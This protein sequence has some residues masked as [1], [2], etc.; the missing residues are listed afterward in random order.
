MANTFVIVPLAKQQGM[1]AH[2][3]HKKAHQHKESVFQQLVD[4]L[5]DTGESGK[6]EEVVSTSTSMKKQPHTS[7]KHQ[8]HAENSVTCGTSESSAA[9]VDSQT[10]A[11]EGTVASETAKSADASNGSVDTNGVQSV[12]NALPAHVNVGRR[13]LLR[14]HISAEL[15]A[16][17]QEAP[18][19]AV[20]SQGTDRTVSV[21]PFFPEAP[22][23]VLTAPSSSAAGT[24]EE[25]A[26]QMA[27]S[28]AASGQQAGPSAFVLP[29]AARMPGEPVRP[30]AAS[31]REI[32]AAQTVDQAI[33]NGQSRQGLA[34]GGQQADRR[35]IPIPSVSEASV[36]VLTVPSSSAAGTGEDT[37]AGQ[38]AASLAA[39]G[40]QAGPSASV[41]PGAARVPGEP[42]RPSA[43]SVREMHAAQTVD[44]AALVGQAMPSFG[45][46]TGQA[47]RLAFMQTTGIAATF[48]SD[49]DAASSDEQVGDTSRLSVFRRDVPVDRHIAFGDRF[50][51]AARQVLTDSRGTE[52]QVVHE[53]NQTT[54]SSNVLPTN[55]AA[56]VAS[57]QMGAI[58]LWQSYQTTGSQAPSPPTRQVADQLGSWF[59][60]STFQGNEQGGTM[61]TLTL[62]P[63]SLG[64]VTVT[65][66]QTQDGITARL[67]TETRTAHDL[68]KAG[69][70]ELKNDLAAQGVAVQ[71]I[72]VGRQ[73]ERA[74]ES[75]GQQQH[76]TDQHSQQQSDAR[77]DEERRDNESRSQ[78]FEA[79][80]VSNSQFDRVL[81]EGSGYM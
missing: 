3:A 66:V 70:G 17:E 50:T 42:V 31:V 45:T 44:Q 35:A 61:L 13:E 32:H 57:R 15:H 62:Y 46:S 54:L 21:T 78:F 2:A 37:S 60:S 38:M 7:S 25:S 77:G 30:S 52:A 40:Q 67:L 47:D 20:N 80:R 36:T 65:V 27:A 29:G 74:G 72:D 14:S 34:A 69:I 28:L 11:A 76:G 73:P 9:T 51:A 49:S 75:P 58:A 43:A 56:S 18:R 33:P 41:L 5:D 16:T 79:V 71:H 26:G 63:E 53:A 23:T 22:A 1:S 39:S 12:G 4:T 81:E 19:V 59:G 64:Q 6:G 68:L 55:A 10:A 24:G 48:A 8:R